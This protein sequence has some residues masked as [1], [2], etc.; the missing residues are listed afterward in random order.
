MQIRLWLLAE[1]MAYRQIRTSE[2]E[3]TKG[4]PAKGIVQSIVGQGYHR[5]I[6]LSS[7][8]LQKLF[9]DGQSS[10]NL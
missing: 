8:L 9:N 7:S 4:L 10:A 5:K 1:C 6:V 3:E 2:Q